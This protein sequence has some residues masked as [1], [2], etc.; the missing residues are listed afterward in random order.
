MAILNNVV[1]TGTGLYNAQTLQAEF[2]RGSLAYSPDID[3]RLPK[4]D[5]I[6][7]NLTALSNAQITVGNILLFPEPDPDNGRYGAV[8]VKEEVILY[9]ARFV[10]NSIL[11]VLTRNVANTTNSTILG[12]IQAGNVITSLG[13][14]TVSS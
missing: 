8:R 1:V 3:P 12:N 10:G 9:A 2:L 7:S 6:T 5:T 13:L 14:R 11:A 4:H